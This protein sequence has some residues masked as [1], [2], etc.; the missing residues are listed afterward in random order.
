[1]SEQQ[2]STNKFACAEWIVDTNGVSA[3]AT[4]STIAAAL[5]SAASGDTIFIK[6]GTYTENLTLKAGVNLAAF[7]CDSY[8]GNVIIAGN[9]TATFTGAASFSGIQFKTNGTYCISVTGTEATVLDFNYCYI[10][11]SNSD[12]IVLS[13][14]NSSSRVRLNYCKGDLGTTGIRFFALSNAGVI[15]INYSI[16][17]NRGLST[18][19]STVANTSI[20]VV[21]SSTLRFPITTSETVYLDVQWSTIAASNTTAITHNSTTTSALRNA[22][23]TS[24]T[25]SAFSIGAG[26]VLVG[27]NVITICT[28]ANAITGSGT[29]QGSNHIFEGTSTVNVTTFSG[30]YSIGNNYFAIAQGAS[31]DAYLQTKINGGQASTFGIDNSDSD[32]CALSASSTLGTTNVMRVSTAGE[33][34]YP[35]QPAFLAYNS[36]TDTSQTGNA[37][38]VTVEFDTEVYD[39]NSDYNTTTDTFTAPVTG[40]Y[41]LFTIIRITNILNASSFALKMVTSNR[42]Y[43]IRPGSPAVQ[44]DSNGLVTHSLACDAD[45]DAGDTAYVTL[46]VAGETSNRITIIGQ[47]APTVVTYFCGQLKC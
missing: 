10:N 35:L 23:V 20:L 1:M 41:Y 12:A 43:E 13:S 17:D 24:G 25:G 11:A 46:E 8:N 18:I 4:H 15:S 45:L 16:I 21:V 34:N 29:Y 26:A 40:K 31:L 32:A 7:D 6:P 33:I 19:S 47:S 22:Y 37:A 2:V 5:T 27:D 14:T 36:T 44:K 42:T 38:I 28:N 9:T 39:Q 3:G 30:T